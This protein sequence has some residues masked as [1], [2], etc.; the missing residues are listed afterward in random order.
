MTTHQLEFQKR[1]FESNIKELEAQL[2]KEADF[3]TFFQEATRL[4]PSR[5][6]IK[7][8]VCGVQVEDIKDPLMQNIR[9]LAIFYPADW[10]N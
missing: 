3:E 6:L 7:G 2:E 1:E 4:N 10:V 9:Y 8:V 5:V